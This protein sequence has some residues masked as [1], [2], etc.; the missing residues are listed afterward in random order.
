MSRDPDGI[1]QI[2]LW[3]FVKGT[4]FSAISA[5]LEPSPKTLYAFFRYLR[6][7]IAEDQGW[8]LGAPCGEVQVD[9]IN[10]GSRD[11]RL[12]SAWN[13]HHAVRPTLI[14]FMDSAGQVRTAPIQNRGKDQVVPAVIQHVPIDS[15]LITNRLRVFGCLREAGFPQVHQ[16]ALSGFPAGLRPAHCEYHLVDFW[17]EVRTSLGKRRGVRDTTFLQHIKEIELRWN[18]RKMPQADLYRHLM[19]VLRSGPVLTSGKH[20]PIIP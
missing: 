13:R 7:R 1:Y 12:R 2:A 6:T 17:K 19:K 4:A 16:I 18:F 9:T 11:G 3:E 10:F 8:P 20:S 5:Q 14:G 15:A